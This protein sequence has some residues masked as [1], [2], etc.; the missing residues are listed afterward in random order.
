MSNVRAYGTY[1]NVPECAPSKF[2]S[3][4]TFPPTHRK[5]AKGQT[6][7]R[8]TLYYY[9]IVRERLVWLAE[10]VFRTKIFSGRLNPGAWRGDSSP[11]AAEAKLT[12][13]G[14]RRGFSYTIKNDVSYRT[15]LYRG[16]TMRFSL[17]I[18]GVSVGRTEEATV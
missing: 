17:Y 4:K 6:R 9:I 3:G 1:E 15:I 12:A 5:R 8:V 11:A 13:R 7:S 16:E 2:I 10:C 14:D 18:Y